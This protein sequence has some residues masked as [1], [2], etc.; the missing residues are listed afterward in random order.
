MEEDEPSGMVFQHTAARR[1]LID[2]EY[3]FAFFGVSTHSRPKAADMD[4]VSVRSAVGFNTQPP[5]GGWR[6]AAWPS[7]LRLF[8]HTAARRRLFPPKVG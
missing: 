6:S 8:Q 3:E 1:R 7:F 2:V 4:S 5:E